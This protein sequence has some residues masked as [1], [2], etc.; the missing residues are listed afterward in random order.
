M[1]KK[2]LLFFLPLI[3]F[4]MFPAF[5]KAA[6]ISVKVDYSALTFDQ[7][8]FIQNGSTYIPLRGITEVTGGQVTWEDATQLITIVK[9]GKK[10]VFKLGD[11][12]A[13]VNGVKKDIPVSMLKN[14]R[15]MIPIRFVSE[16]LGLNVQWNQDEYT[17][18]VFTETM[19][20]AQ[21]IIQNAEKYIG[22]RYQYGGTY[23]TTKTFD[24]SSFVQQ[25]FKEKGVTLPR[26]T[27]DQVKVGKAVSYSQLQKGD[28]VFF[29]IAG[30]GSISHVAI[31]VDK[32]KLLQ[33]T[34]S[35]GVT[36]TDFGSYWSSRVK[37]YRRVL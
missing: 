14:N 25:V 37:E 4:V 33:A 26:T 18:Y 3:L 35:K 2:L 31:Y 32:N 15:T 7:M 22:I 17:V 11:S 19:T 1:N 9:D 21:A 6:G 24:C 12:I 29:D 8:P 36:Y 13:Y 28:L 23:S 27:Y 16:N 30:N 34:S 5:A 10:I 20:Q